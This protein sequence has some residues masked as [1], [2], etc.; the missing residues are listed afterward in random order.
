MVN[1]VADVV[2]GVVGSGVEFINVERSA[3]VKRLTRITGVA[4]FCFCGWIETIDGFGQDAG[5]SGF[6]TPLE[7]QNKKA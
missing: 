1:E 3:R 6:S 4:S 7:P 5:G 2:H